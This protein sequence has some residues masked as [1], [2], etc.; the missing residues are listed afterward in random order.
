MPF[1]EIPRE[2]FPHPIALIITH[3][4][5]PDDDDDDVYLSK[6]TTRGLQNLLSIC[7]RKHI[8]LS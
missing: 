5:L 1:E 3:L 7:I 2:F 4:P 8:D 6:M